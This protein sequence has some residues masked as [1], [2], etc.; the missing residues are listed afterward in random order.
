MKIRTLGLLSY[1]DGLREMEH[2]RARVE[3]GGQDEIL[4]LEH[5]SVVTLGK[6][7]GDWDRAR[8]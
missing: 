6:R 5:E 2:T 7:G 1:R 3:A 8:L 4:L